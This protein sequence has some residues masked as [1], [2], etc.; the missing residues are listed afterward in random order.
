[1]LESYFN[2]KVPR[3]RKDGEFWLSLRTEPQTAGG[4]PF[5]FSFHPSK[6]KNALRISLNLCGKMRK[7]TLQWRTALQ[8]SINLEQHC[9]GS[10]RPWMWWVQPWVKGQRDAPDGFRVAGSRGCPCIPFREPWAAQGFSPQPDFLPQDETNVCLKQFLSE[11][12]NDYEKEKKTKTKNQPNSDLVVIQSLSSRAGQ[13]DLSRGP[14]SAGSEI[15]GSQATGL[16]EILMGCLPTSLLRVLMSG[17]VF[18][19]SA[20]SPA[21]GMD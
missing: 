10:K 11:P 12:G 13:N 14:P 4:L 5:S 21:P 20:S 17:T 16:G 6:G 9:L 15:C 8:N 19:S 18:V 7:F 2:Q 3:T 1:M